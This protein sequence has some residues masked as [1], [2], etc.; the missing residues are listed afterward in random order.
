MSSVL[1]TLKTRQKTTKTTCD[2]PDRGVSSKPENISLSCEKCNSQEWW[3]AKLNFSPMC[4]YC[5][6][7]PTPKLVAEH[8]FYDDHNARWDIVANRD[9]S[10]SWVRR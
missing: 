9:G 1:E 3:I 6:P 4:F 10:E 7:P 8:F 5:D 2:T